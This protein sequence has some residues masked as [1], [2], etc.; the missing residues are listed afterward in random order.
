MHRHMYAVVSYNSQI[1]MKKIIAIIIIT[2]IV[3][4]TPYQKLILIP[5]N[6]N[7]ILKDSCDV[8]VINK[9]RQSLDTIEYN[10][11]LDQTRLLEEIINECECDYY[12]NKFYPPRED[13][14][15]WLMT[16]QPVIVGKDEIILGNLYTFYPKQ[17]ST[18]IFQR[19]VKEYSQMKEFESGKY[20][21]F[22]F[23]VD[24]DTTTMVK[25]GTS[26]F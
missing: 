7:N 24:N 15:I 5:A 1:Q 22:T 13:S 20:L 21:V 9:L 4:C 14:T 26:M 2:S 23:F 3:S 11:N 16:I 18:F 6:R 17:D 19:R 12:A 10:K 8:L 25:V